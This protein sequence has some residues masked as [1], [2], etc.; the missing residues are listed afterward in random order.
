MTVAGFGF[1]AAATLESLRG[2]LA[3]AGGGRV[4]ALAAPKDKVHAAPLSA[5]AAALDVPIHGVAPASLEAQSTLTP[6]GPNA[7]RY[8]KGSVAE[9]AA[10]AA[11]GRG[12]RLRGPRSVSPDGCA[13]CAL[14]ENP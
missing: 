10:L 12:A 7:R 3:A 5:L 2:A 14:A 1:R 6:A 9:A 4:D 11:A 8:G 13:T